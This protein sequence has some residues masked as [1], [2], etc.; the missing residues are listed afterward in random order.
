MEQHLARPVREA[1]FVA[2]G[3]QQTIFHFAV[4]GADGTDAAVQR[5]DCIDGAA[6]L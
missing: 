2:L 6:I 3:E 5:V 1:F 4:R